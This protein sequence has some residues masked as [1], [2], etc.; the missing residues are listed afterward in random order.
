LKAIHNPKESGKLQKEMAGRYRKDL[1]KVRANG[2]YRDE[3]RLLLRESSVLEGTKV[4]E[5]ANKC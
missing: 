2:R 3:K 5:Q 1:R 4:R